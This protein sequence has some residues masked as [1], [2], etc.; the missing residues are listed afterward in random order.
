MHMIDAGSAARRVVIAW[1]TP[2]PWAAIRADVE[3]LLRACDERCAARVPGWIGHVKA[4]V[5]TPEDAVYASTT[6]AGEPVSWRGAW[7]GRPLSGLTLTLYGAVYGATDDA[8]DAI[9]ASALRDRF[10]DARA[11]PRADNAGGGVIPL[12]AVP[13]RGLRG[14][15]GGPGAP[16][17]G[18]HEQAKTGD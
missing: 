15:A 6:G 5:R 13:R 18:R 11:A 9:I 4:L 3:A 8:L 2:R 14:G 12:G 10:P 17:D 1:P 16:P 7:D